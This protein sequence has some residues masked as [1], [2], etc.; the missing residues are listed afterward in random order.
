MEHSFKPFYFGT[1]GLLLPVPNKTHYPPQFQDKS[2]LCYYSF[3]MNSIEINSSFYRIPLPRTIKSW[4][5]DVNADFKFTFKLFNGI[6]HQKDL[7]FEPSLITQFFTAI[8]QVETKKACVLV[9]LPPSITLN[10]YIKINQL[11]LALKE[12]ELSHPW[13]IAFEFRHPSLYCEEI[14]EL[15]NEFNFGMVIH[16]KAKSQSPV[17]GSET[18]FVYL[19]FHG[20]DGNYRST[21]SDDI[22]YEYSTY[23]QEWLVDEKTVFTYFNNTMG[24]THANL[25]TLRQYI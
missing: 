3:L 1:S 4:A 6:T 14:N 13:K 17:L 2:R 7:A 8:N 23:I 25:T 21:Y 11:M 9:Q 15:L 16:D 24:N 18:D 10:H 22:L 5:N 20:P 12:N 19:R